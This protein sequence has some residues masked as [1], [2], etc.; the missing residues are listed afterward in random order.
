[1]NDLRASETR[2]SDAW[3]KARER[4]FVESPESPLAEPA[5][6]AFAGIPR[7]PD[8]PRWRLSAIL[9]REPRRPSLLGA[10]G[11]D[12]PK[13]VRVGQAEFTFGGRAWRLTVFE[14]EA[15]V[16]EPYIFIPFRDATSGKETYGG[17]R[18]LDTDPPREDGRFTL[19]F[20]MSYHPFC[21]YDEAW[22]CTIPPMENRLDVP[23]HAGERWP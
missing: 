17:G 23:V 19:D 18:Y 14:P 2:S 22:A 12:T 13:F 21:V 16:D 6:K 5:R 11:A 7:W 10:T 15:K 9:V 4:W 3:W 20:N 8:D 1:M